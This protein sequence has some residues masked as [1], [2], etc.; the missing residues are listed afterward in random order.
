MRWFLALILVLSFGS[1]SSARED[2]VE[3]CWDSVY[4][5]N[6]ELMVQAYAHGDGD[7]HLELEILQDLCFKYWS[8]EYPLLAWQSLAEVVAAAERSGDAEGFLED[9]GASLEELKGLIHD[10]K[11]LDAQRAYRAFYDN[12]I[13]INQYG[14]YKEDVLLQL[15]H[16]YGQLLVE[17]SPEYDLLSSVYFSASDELFEEIDRELGFTEPLERSV[18]YLLGCTG[19]GWVGFPT[20]K[21]AQV[22]GLYLLPAPDFD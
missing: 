7:A 8:G 11:I 17:D 16:A 21:L 13:N 15:Y 9:R 12:M 10:W 1:V 6:E 22:C 19:R 14:S 4:E 20:L 5:E 2:P 3:D 18:G